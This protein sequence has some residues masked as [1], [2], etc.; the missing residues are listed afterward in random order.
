VHGT[1][2]GGAALLQLGKAAGARTTLQ[3]QP[4]LADDPD[5]EWAAHLLATTADAMGAATFTA[6]PGDWC[7]AC[8]LQSSCPAREEG[9]RL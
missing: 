3:T 5:P 4:A 6:T 7:G 2:S 8:Q 1:R 9:R